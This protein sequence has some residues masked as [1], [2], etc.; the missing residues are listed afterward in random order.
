M[1]TGPTAAAPQGDAASPTYQRVVEDVLGSGLTQVEV[2]QVVGASVRTVQTWTKG[3]V[4]PGGQKVK[5]LLDL[6]YLIDELRVAYTD[7]GV[8]IWLR[9]R[10]RN[11]NGRRPVDLLLEGEMDAVLTEAQRISGAMS[12]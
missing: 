10:N 7:E 9:S 11:L 5:R 12:G 4:T 1:T 3:G 2:G 6:R 8:D